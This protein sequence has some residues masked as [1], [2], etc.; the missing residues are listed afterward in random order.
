MRASTPGSPSEVVRS[1]NNVIAMNER[2]AGKFERVSRVV[3][4]E[5][6]LMARASVKGARGS[7]GTSVSSVNTLIGDLVQAT[8]EVARVIGEVAKGNLSRTMP[9][10]IES[11]PVKGAFLQM[12]ETINTMVGHLKAFA[13]SGNPVRSTHRFSRSSP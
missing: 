8:I 10:A 12:A 1:L 6:K 11:R 5:G 7:W 9:M 4:K 2:E 3:G 13:S